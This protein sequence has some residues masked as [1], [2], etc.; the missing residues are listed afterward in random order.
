[1]EPVQIHGQTQAGKC[2]VT[3]IGK[4]LHKIL[5][6]MGFTVETFNGVVSIMINAITVKMKILVIVRM[7]PH[8]LKSRHD[9]K[10]RSRRI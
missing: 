10:G 4:S 7:L 1:M 9:L 2:P 5:A 6:S 3:G 8:I